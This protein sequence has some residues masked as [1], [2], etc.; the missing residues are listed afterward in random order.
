MLNRLLK[1]NKVF[2]F[3]FVSSFFATFLLMYFGLDFYREFMLIKSNQV[4]YQ[5]DVVNQYYVKYYD[6][7]LENEK[8]DLNLGNG[9]IFRICTLP[10]GAKTNRRYNIYI[11]L[12]NNE[13][14]LEEI[15]EGD[16]NQVVSA[17]YK[18][19]CILGDFWDKY[20]YIRNGK[21][22]ILIGGEEIEVIATFKQ[23]SIKGYDKRLYVLGK[24]I[25]RDVLE[26]WCKTSRNY[27][28]LYKSIKSNM[29]NESLEEKLAS[30]FDIESIGE[31]I[32]DSSWYSSTKVLKNYFPIIKFLLSA[33][34]LLTFI[35]MVFLSLVWSKTHIYEYML[36]RT[37]GF[38]MIQLIPDILIP[39]FLYEILGFLMMSIITI[40]Y[41]TIKNGF[42]AWISNFV[43]G[44]TFVA[45]LFAGIPIVLSLLPL[46]W[47]SR[48]QPVV[49]IS[50][51][52]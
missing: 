50:S 16:L 15:N 23:I 12:Y 21:K 38:S 20:A 22:Y 27:E 32:N 8:I 48:Q 34:F 14:L 39:I 42:S 9:N 6:D 47:L 3:L 46:K 11:W 19:S 43:N 17:S 28:Y 10:I 36:K 25:E 40:T 44:V 5:Y 52:E 1:T 30:Y 35:N 49:V 13:K 33:M 31:T 2:T 41:E 18:P 51:R 29:G 26:R 4:F 24:T 45:L 37:F 7:Y